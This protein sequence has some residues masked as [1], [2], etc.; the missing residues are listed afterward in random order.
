MQ[1]V[2]ARL[3]QDPLDPGANVAVERIRNVLAQ[4][5]EE[6]A[7]LDLLSEEGRSKI[8]ELPKGRESWQM[9]SRL[10]KWQYTHR[11]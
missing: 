1:R 3:L 4:R 10:A 8:D 11:H 7:T 2:V 9:Q 5:Y 6:V